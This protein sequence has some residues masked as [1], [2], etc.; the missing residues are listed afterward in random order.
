M[1]CRLLI[2]HPNLA[3]Q[4][5]LGEVLPF[6]PERRPRKQPR[7]RHSI[8]RNFGRGFSGSPDPVAGAGGAN[9]HT[10]APP[11]NT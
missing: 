3:L 2:S 6:D 4:I 9:T 8:H 10:K 1:H 5:G 11:L 7:N